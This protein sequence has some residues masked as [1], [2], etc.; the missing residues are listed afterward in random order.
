MGGRAG[1]IAAAAAAAA[2][3]GGVGGGGGANA[4]HESLVKVLLRVDCIQPEVIDMLLEKI[5]E[6]VGEEETAAEGGYGSGAAA[7]ERTFSWQDLPR[8][9][10]NQVRFL[11]HLVDSTSLTR[12]ILEVLTVLPVNLQREMIS[13]LPEVVE[14]GDH[15]EVVET[16]QSLKDSEPQLLVAVLDALGNLSLPPRLLG[17]IT[18]DALGLLDSAQPSTLP[19]LVRFL[20]ETATADTADAVVRE[21][22]ERLRLCPVVGGGGRGGVEDT[23][24]TE[25]LVLNP[26]LQSNREPPSDS[27][28]SG[29][30]LTLE[31][32]RQGLRLRGDLA[33]CFLKA[34]TKTAGSEG[35][36]VVDLWV[37]FCLYANQDTRKRVIALFRR[38]ISCGHF[39][40]PL[41][42][43]ALHGRAGALH[44]LFFSLMGITDALVSSGVVSVR[45]YGA[46]MYRE[47]FSGF[48]EAYH[49]QEV[50]G[51]LIT[52]CG[53]GSE[54]ETDS[55]LSALSAL[56]SPSDGG[57][58]L[59]PFAAFIRALMDY[60]QGYTH[61][62][63]R[64]VFRILCA[65]ASSAPGGRDMSAGGDMDDVHIFVRKHVAMS[66]MA[67]KQIGIIGAVAFVEF[68][69]KTG[70]GDGPG[71][72]G[73]MFSQDSQAGGGS[74]LGGSTNGGR[75]QTSGAGDTLA[76]LM[77]HCRNSQEGKAFL[78][79]ELALSAGT[80][81]L[82]SD[83]L[84]A[85]VNM[86]LD[87]LTEEFMN[88]VTVGGDGDEDEEEAEGTGGLTDEQKKIL[89]DGKFSG[90]LCGGAVKA[91]PY[92][93]LDQAVEGQVAEV[94]LLPLLASEDQQE[95]M[96]IGGLCPLFSLLATCL[97]S[98]QCGRELDEIAAALGAPVIL[99]DS[100]TV[101]NVIHLEESHKNAVIGAHYAACNWVRELVN[102]FVLETHSDF[103]AKLVR[104]I[105]HLCRLEFDL[106]FMLKRH[107]GYR[108]P[109]TGKSIM[110]PANSSIGKKSG[111]ASS[112]SSSS[113]TTSGNKGK[114]K[115]KAK[116]PGKASKKTEGE[117]SEVMR[118][119]LRRSLR[120]LA[121]EAVL[122]LGF[123]GMLQKT[124]NTVGD[125]VAV[126][127]IKVGL[128]GVHLLLQE[129]HGHLK[130]ALADKNS[131]RAFSRLREAMVGNSL[132]GMEDEIGV[133]CSDVSDEEMLLPCL[134][135]T[136][137][138]LSILCGSDEILG[139]EAGR[140]VLGECLADAFYDGDLDESLDGSQNRPA[141]D[142]AFVM[143]FDKL[144]DFASTVQQ[145]PLAVQL[146]QVMEA[147]ATAR[148]R[149]L[150]AQPDGRGAAARGGQRRGETPELSPHQKLSS[151]CLT[152]LQRD[153][154][155]G[156]LKFVYKS[157]TLGVLVRAHLRWAKDPLQAVEVMGSEVL[158]LLLETGD[159]LGPAEGYPT[160][161]AASFSH[162]Y[163]PLLQALLSCWKDRT[164]FSP[165][166]RLPTDA[167]LMRTERMVLML[168]L[169]ILF[170]K[171]NPTLSRRLVLVSAL[172]ESK[173]I[174]QV[175]LKSAMSVLERAFDSNQD[176]VLG[177][178]K[179]LQQ[180]TRQMQSLCAH[181]KDVGD[182]AMSKEAPAVKKLLEEFI[183]RMKSLVQS[184]D[185]YGAL[186]VGNLKNRSLDGELLVVPVE[187]SEDEEP[188]ER[189][190]GNEDSDSDSSDS[191][192]G[193]AGKR[194]VQADD[195]DNAEEEEE[196]EEEE[197]EEEE[198]EEEQ[199]EEEEDGE[200]GE[201][202]VPLVQNNDSG[203]ET[204]SDG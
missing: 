55:A 192:S 32:L 95:R 38:K 51:A 6:L 131:T 13:Y 81:A 204:D 158:P 168:K 24:E 126:E 140:N 94:L 23:E 63:V 48:S 3:G 56:A 71:P 143:C 86:L 42:T 35:H 135:F 116:A 101:D 175:F 53:A 87:P 137:K 11:D 97:R 110:S 9:V 132:G 150:A 198:E 138:V 122:V 119:T 68:H 29:D 177:I 160:L 20:L 41:M 60:M 19:V 14:D 16:L 103:K 151:L 159:C 187:E 70:G 127:S 176:E 106:L 99:A 181:G 37:L 10:L 78:Y 185:C 66:Q 147:V 154:S 52:H 54:L 184:N 83:A 149:C 170:T 180:T 18:E 125:T 112:S 190:E 203:S 191:D 152:L 166:S 157:S 162:F 50:V 117:Q 76:M 121:P 145:L 82:G 172:R 64:K 59:R 1:F 39:T 113:S 102:A 40:E 142:E 189:N 43:D 26:G 73:G 30:A 7:R 91:S 17:G 15:A 201:D 128:R 139:S 25:A 28:T 123:P 90:E 93:N 4:I 84:D 193:R 57:S 2:A 129:M 146:V 44:G 196:E 107:L 62:Q 179:G 92:G 174:M 75:F 202:T 47:I 85:L 77:N 31:A 165:R 69:G 27:D 118:D 148:V 58:G 156:D 45:R 96:K 33:A 5:P 65:M 100:H 171:G 36:S 141:A 183:F 34:I 194:R 89:E 108:L 199:E 163:T 182:A 197:D 186:S 8:L 144:E 124:R 22:R 74:A 134:D 136:L 164:D 80:G 105:G 173:K 200:E 178:V 49:R 104:R 109:G 161:T 115:G 67:L 98:P 79:D 133:F 167:V 12:K 111:A 72:A 61:Y 114:G 88:V 130:R 120:P 169:L 46:S 21:L 155:E 153:W 195:G 188:P